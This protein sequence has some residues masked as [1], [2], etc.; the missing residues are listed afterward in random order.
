MKNKIVIEE[1]DW[2]TSKYRT[3]EWEQSVSIIKWEH[4]F[5]TKK[6]TIEFKEI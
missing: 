4:D 6:Y 3:K 5:E 1:S 2:C